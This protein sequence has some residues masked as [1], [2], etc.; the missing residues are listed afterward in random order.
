MAMSA[1]TT[2]WA[3]DAE[4]RRQRVSDAKRHGHADGRVVA[5]FLD[6]GAVGGGAA[7]ARRPAEE[8]QDSRRGPACLPRFQWPRRHRRTALPAPRRWSLLWPQRGVR[9][10]L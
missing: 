3:T 8:D 4:P 7:R 1:A 5:P 6:A 10:A 9:I 2:G